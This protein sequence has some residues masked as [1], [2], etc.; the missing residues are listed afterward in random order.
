MATKHKENRCFRIQKQQNTKKINVFETNGNKTQGKSMRSNPKATKHKENRCVR[1]QMQQNTRQMCFS[2]FLNKFDEKR[3]FNDLLV[4]HQENKRFRTFFEP[5]S[6]KTQWISMFFPPKQLVCKGSLIIIPAST[7]ISCSRI[8][9]WTWFQV[10]W[11]QV[12]WR[13]LGFPAPGS[14]AGPDFRSRGFR[15]RG[16]RSRGEYLGFW[17]PD[18]WLDLIS[19]PVASGP[20]ELGRFFWGLDLARTMLWAPY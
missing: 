18:R 7:W 11:L 8:G 4:K 20:V 9:S 13:V 3:V 15:S 5:K 14:V 1:T 16:F 17:L 19:S 10:P 2:T 12:P 6:K